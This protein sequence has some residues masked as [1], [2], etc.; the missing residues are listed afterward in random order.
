MHSRGDFSEV[1]ETLRRP[2]K[3]QLPYLGILYEV[4]RHFRGPPTILLFNKPAISTV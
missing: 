1:L 4:Y 2:V 3:V